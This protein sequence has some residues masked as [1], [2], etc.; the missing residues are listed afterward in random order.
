MPADSFLLSMP[1]HRAGSEMM[2]KIVTVFEPNLERGLPSHFAVINAFDAETGACT[3]VI[4]GTYIT[5]VRTAGSAAVSTRLLAR[6]DARRLAIVGAG[7]QGRAHLKTVPLT[8][9]FE[10]IAICSLHHEDAE[11]LAREHPLARA[12]RDAEAAV[13]DADVVALA[14]HAAEPVI[15]AAWL[16]PGAH[17]SSVGYNPPVGELPAEAID[18]GRLFV[19][20][21]LAFEP[22]PVGCAE[23]AGRDPAAATELGEVVT[24]AR[25]GRSSAGELTVYKAMGHAIEDL[26]AADLVLA[27]ARRTGAGRAVDLMAG[28]PTG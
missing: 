19:E 15:D 6:E 23:L 9:A 12:E 14:T 21:R 26:V 18:R 13:R 2:V 28:R 8:R 20:T 7:V 1:A 17:V 24:G 27:A 4:D 10:D 3:A 25:P 16:K 11:R 5:A 22:T